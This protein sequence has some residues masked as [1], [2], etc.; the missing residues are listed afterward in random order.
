MS[1]I[2]RSFVVIIIDVFSIRAFVVKVFPHTKIHK[3]YIKINRD[4]K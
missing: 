2:F 3:T 4:Q 1:E